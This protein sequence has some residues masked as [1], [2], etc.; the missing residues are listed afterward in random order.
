M[1]KLMLLFLSLAVL[2]G[3]A[4]CSGPS[5]APT[6]APT[7]QPRPTQSLSANPQSGG[8]ELGSAAWKWTQVVTAAGAST[9]VSNGSQ[10]TLQF[11][12]SNGRV[13]LVTPC[14]SVGGTYT[15]NGQ[16][17][18]I[19][20]DSMTN[21]VCPGDTLSGQFIVQVAAV[22]SYHLDGGDLVL[23]LGGD[24]GTLRLAH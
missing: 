1:R 20:L 19:T 7:A 23:T 11:D 13:A 6:S 5:A 12:A 10:Y 21:A 2:A 8:P 14:Q 3:L 24:G 22:Q 15:V 9:A 17:L 16:S 4:A 18:K